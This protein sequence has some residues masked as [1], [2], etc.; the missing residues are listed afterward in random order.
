MSKLKFY[1]LKTVTLFLKNREKHGKIF[2]KINKF[3]FNIINKWIV[4]EWKR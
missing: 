3:S 1:Y 2:V 4:F